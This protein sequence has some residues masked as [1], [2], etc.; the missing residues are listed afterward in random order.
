MATT[1]KKAQPIVPKE[2]STVVIDKKL[3]KI[4]SVRFTSG[5]TEELKK[6]TFKVSF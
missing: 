1:K 2:T 3:D 5:K 6:L 4:K